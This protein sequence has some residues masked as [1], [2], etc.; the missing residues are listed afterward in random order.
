MERR[1][2]CETW[3]G[4]AVRLGE[5]ELRLG[6]EEELRLGGETW[7]GDLEGRSC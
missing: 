5:E 1:R 7:R 3:R 4:G 6:E 2:S